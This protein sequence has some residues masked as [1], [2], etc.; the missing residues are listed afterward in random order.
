[1][2]ILTKAVAG[3]TIEASDDQPNLY[4]RVRRVG[5]GNKGERRRMSGLQAVVLV[6]FIVLTVAFTWAMSKK[7]RK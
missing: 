1:M 7:W 4:W 3:Y 2:F 6:I 5:N